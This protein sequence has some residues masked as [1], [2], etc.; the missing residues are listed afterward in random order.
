[1][2]SEPNGGSPSVTSRTTPPTV[3]ELERAA[4]LFCLL[5]EENAK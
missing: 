3:P 5:A 1:M 4:A 2:A